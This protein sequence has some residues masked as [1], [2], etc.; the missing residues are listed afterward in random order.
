[1]QITQRALFSFQFLFL[2][3]S[4]HDL[5]HSG[6]SREKPYVLPEFKKYQNQSN[7][8]GG[9]DGVWGNETGRTG[10]T[11]VRGNQGKFEKCQPQKI[12]SK[13]LKTPTNKKFFQKKEVSK[14]KQKTKLKIAVESFLPKNE[15]M[16]FS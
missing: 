7:I 9:Q 11:S 15:E 12:T 14:Q 1:M 2:T 16:V 8:K 4:L 5:Q 6:L 3:K 10:T 13:I